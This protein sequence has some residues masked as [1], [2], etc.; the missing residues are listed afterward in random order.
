MTTKINGGQIDNYASLTRTSA[1]AAGKTGG[2]QA[3]V[4]TTAR[5]DS[6]SLTTDAQLLQLTANAANEASGIDPAR[7]ASVSAEL[8][9]GSYKVDPQAIAAK[10]MKS[11]WEIYG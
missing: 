2:K 8:A 5:G 3:P 6:L 1:T 7:V 9:N 11:D 10:M 4:V